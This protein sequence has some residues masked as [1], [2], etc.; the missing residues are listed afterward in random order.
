VLRGE[1]GRAVG[2]DVLAEVGVHPGRTAAARGVG[3]AEVQPAGPVI[4]EHPAR[5]AED[6]AHR[7]DVGGGG[8][9]VAVLASDA[10]VTLAPVGRAG[11]DAV[12][13]LVGHAGKYAP[14][15]ANVE[16]P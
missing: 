3:V 1:A 7:V 4:G 12:R 13:G 8:V 15:V 2:G 10:V 16:R 9:F 11:D 6:I 14:D 5:L